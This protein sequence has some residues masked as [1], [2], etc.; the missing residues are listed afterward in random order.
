MIRVIGTLFLLGVIVEASAQFSYSSDSSYLKFED[1]IH[2]LEVEVI[3]PVSQKYQV[4]SK[5]Q[6]FSLI[7][8]QNVAFGSLTDLI[9]R[10][11]PIYIRSDAGGLGTFRFRGT[12]ST[13]TSVLVGGIN[14]NS[15]TLGSSNTN[16]I[17]IYL[18]DEINLSFGSSSATTG[19]GSIGGSVRLG[20]NNHWTNGTKG[21]IFTSIGSFGEYVGGSKIFIGNGKFESVTRLLLYQKENNFPYYNTAYYNRELKRYERDTLR[22]SS[23]TNQHV[24]QQFN[25]K[26][27]KNQS[28]T[29]FFWFSKNLHEAQ[30]NMTQNKTSTPRPIED[31]NFRSCV[32]YNLNFSKYKLKLEA[33]YV[34]DKNIDNKDRINTIGTHRLISN[35]GLKSKLRRFNYEVNLNYKYI[36]PKVY[37][38]DENITEEHL[39]LHGSI[40]CKITPKLKASLN[41][42]QQYVT[43]FNAPFT[44]SLGIDYIILSQE[45]SIIKL[46]TNIQRSYK[47][48]TFNDRFWNQ[49]D[50]EGNKDINSEDGINYEIGLN[51][52]LCNN[53]LN[54]ELAS[55][56]YYMDVDN[57]ILWKPEGNSWRAQNIL[58]VISKGL[59][60]S[61]D[62]KIDF[63]QV[64]IHSG[65]NYSFN[66]AVRKKSKSEHYALNRQL[67]YTPKSLAN[68]FFT[69]GYKNYRINC[70]ASQVGSRYY[71]Q[72]PKYLKSYSL[73]NASLQRIVKFNQYNILIDA[74][75]NNIFN[76]QYE[77]Q[78]QYAMPERNYR[79]QLKFNF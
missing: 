29:S 67:E 33:G 22:N 25:Y 76:E 12:S 19:S 44:P 48:P 57:W 74:Q 58:Q 42:R 71:D 3:S 28:I 56:A 4:G 32:S 10:Y 36:W 27:D 18:F 30:P 23:I 65:L 5:H 21:E 9:S 11:A 6:E 70:D 72:T 51:Y 31:W 52:I 37:A 16:N 75:A 45:H 47:I 60:F 46:L 39:D 24:L 64:S 40:L 43:R 2:I 63:N 50:F 55:N 53:K 78:F 62:A 15:L 13:H 59:E 73:F 54:L 34:N 14:I 8:K 77:N 17:P 35:F 61:V 41:I 38:Y 1:T 7:Q 20:L 69:F 49:V 26:I 68:A 66:S 79:I